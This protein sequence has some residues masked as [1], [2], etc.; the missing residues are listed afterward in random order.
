MTDDPLPPD[1]ADALASLRTDAELPPGLEARTVRALADDGVIARRHSNWWLALVAAILV[2]AGFA[3]GRVSLA[4]HA[5]PGGRYAVFLYGAPATSADEAGRAA[6]YRSWAR[7]LRAAGKLDDGGRLGP[8]E[9]FP[10]RRDVSPLPP[11]ESPSGYFI[12]RASSLDDAHAIAL[13]CP[14]LSHGGTVSVRPID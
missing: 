7:S 8:G 10:A 12:V 11:V 1:A 4:P 13:T 14:H 5:A 2:A 3:A 6:E 9:V